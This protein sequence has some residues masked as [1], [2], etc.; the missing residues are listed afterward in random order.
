MSLLHHD[1]RRDTFD[2]TLFEITDAML[3]ESGPV[4][5]PVGLVLLAEH[6]RGHGAL[7]DALN[8]GGIDADLVRRALAVLPQPK[9]A[10]NRLVLAVDVSHWLRPGAPCSA[11]RLFCHVYGCNGR[12]SDQPQPTAHLVEYPLER[13]GLRPAGEIP[14]DGAPGDAEVGGKCPSLR[15]VV[16]DVADGV[17]RAASGPLLRGT[18]ARS[19][20]ELLGGRAGVGGSALSRARSMLLVWEGWRWRGSGVAVAGRD[21]WMG[22]A[23]GRSRSV[24]LRVPVLLR[25]GLE[26]RGGL[27]RTCLCRGGAGV[28]VVRGLRL[29]RGSVPAVTFAIRW[30]MVSES[31]RSWPVPGLRRVIRH[32]VLPSGA[33]L[34]CGRVGAASFPGPGPGL[35]WCGVRPV[36]WVVWAAG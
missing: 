29:V 15:T 3:C 32:A 24:A 26:L 33:G 20:Y 9:A 31:A 21:R 12:S 19:C 2:F 35:C 7:Y 36:G 8:C 10:G 1:A 22:P 17:D 13:A 4:T 5:S 28:G 27:D 14:E 6:R 30:W 11:D 34:A 18:S 16:G 23:A 25:A